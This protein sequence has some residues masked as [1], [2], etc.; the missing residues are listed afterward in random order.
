MNARTLR[1]Q[2]NN[3]LTM[4]MVIASAFAVWKGL[5][6]VTNSS[7]P[8]VVV[9][10]GSMEP[11]FQRGDIL[12]LWNREQYLDVGDIVVYNAPQRDIPI[13]HRVVHEH[14]IEEKPKS[15]KGK[16]S[17]TSKLLEEATPKKTQYLLT[18]GDNN[19]RDD[20]PLYGYGKTYLH[21]ENDIVGSVKG[22][23]PK[24][25]YITILITENKYVKYAM[26]G[27][28]AISALFSQE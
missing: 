10:S 24:V 3:L 15:K 22:Y 4:A 9:L 20:L 8:L 25:G 12:F 14:I 7:S 11:A 1:L 13:V 6:V 23:L 17:N 16:K 2:L 28:L 5:S 21:R 27:F 19:E 18:K 26:F